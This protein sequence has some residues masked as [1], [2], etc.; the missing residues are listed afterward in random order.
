MAINATAV[1]TTDIDSTKVLKKVQE[2]T[3]KLS[4]IAASKIAPVFDLDEAQKAVE[5]VYG[6]L[7]SMAD[8][9][10]KPTIDVKGIEAVDTTK[11]ASAFEAQFKNVMKVAQQLSTDISNIFSS[12]D[13]K[14]AGGAKGNKSKALA[15]DMNKL[16][17]STRESRKSIVDGFADIVS[18]ATALKNV[19]PETIASAE[20]IF[21][22][23]KKSL[24]N[25]GGGKV[26]FK[27][28]FGKVPAADLRAAMQGY[29]DAIETASK[30]FSDMLGK[31]SA[32]SV[33]LANNLVKTVESAMQV[34][35]PVSV[36]IEVAKPS[37]GVI[38]KA[39]VG[40]KSGLDTLSLK[41]SEWS[42][43]DFV[44]SFEWGQTTRAITSE[45]EAAFSAEAS[46]RKIF[47]S[48][49]SNN[50]IAGNIGYTAGLWI[51]GILALGKKLS[52]A[53]FAIPSVLA[54]GIA[55]VSSGVFGKLSASI[56][57]GISSLL[58][59][60]NAAFVFVFGALQ[61]VFNKYTIAVASSLFMASN[62]LFVTVGKKIVTS[63]YGIGKSIFSAFKSLFSLGGLGGGSGASYGELSGF[64]LFSLASVATAT[65]LAANL[66]E[67][68]LKVTTITMQ[69]GAAFKNLQSLTISLSNEFGKSA[70]D[71]AA[72]LYDVSSAGFLGN[73]AFSVLRASIQAATAG[74][75]N[76][77]VAS[78]AISRA[79][80]AF[81]L[82]VESATVV[83]DVL[84]NVVK[85]GIT[86]FEDLAQQVTRV[87]TVSNVTGVS[88][89]EL[90]AVLAFLTRNGL[91]TEQAILGVQGL[92]KSLI[93]PSEEAKEAAKN[94]GFE[95]NETALKQKG[96]IKLLQDSAPKILANK[97]VFKKLV[98]EMQGVTA[99]LS[100]ASKP[101]ELTEDLTAMHERGAAAEASAQVA[102]GFNYQ[103]E[104]FW[105]NFVN[106]LRNMGQIILPIIQPALEATVEMLSKLS[107]FAN[108]DLSGFWAGLK[109][110]VAFVGKS[111]LE[112]LSSVSLYLGQ[113]LISIGATVLPYISGIVNSV[114]QLL[115]ALIIKLAPTIFTF[116]VNSLFSRL[117]IL[118]ELIKFSFRSLGH[119]L[120]GELGWIGKGIT[121]FFKS[122]GDTLG[123][124]LE[125]VMLPLNGLVWIVEKI[126]YW[127]GIIDENEKVKV[128]APKFELSKEKKTSIADDMK[129]VTADFAKDFEVGFSALKFDFKKN[130]SIIESV[131]SSFSKFN[132]DVAIAGNKILTTSSTALRDQADSMAEVLKS[133]EEQYKKEI[134]AKQNTKADITLKFIQKQKQQMESLA[135]SLQKSELNDTLQKQQE[136]Y[137]SLAR[138][139]RDGEKNLQLSII[140][141][142]KDNELFIMKLE[143]KARSKQAF[144]NQVIVNQQANLYDSLKAK[145]L[146]LVK[147]GEKLGGGLG[148]LNTVLDD[149]FGKNV[150][151]IA[152]QYGVGKDI[153]DA[154]ELA[155]D[156]IEARAAGFEA[157]DINTI[158]TRGLMQRSDAL[159]NVLTAFK[160]YQRALSLEDV[161][162]M[163]LS[164]QIVRLLDQAE[165][166]GLDAVGR[167]ALL[168]N[169]L[170][171]EALQNLDKQI[172]G[173]KT[174]QFVEQAG[175]FFEGV[176]EERKLQERF[177]V[178]QLKV[179]D[180]T[181]EAVTRNQKLKQVVEE[182]EKK[183]GEI[184]QI[185]G[186]QNQVLIQVP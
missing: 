29:K 106:I 69:T 22:G 170:T 7:K 64:Q 71:V 84:F 95:W 147:A 30:S 130:D 102:L 85:R 143:A 136:L 46:G 111:L 57:R 54:R 17:A 141:Q 126:A 18:Q 25:A 127:L 176:S 158:V 152:K 13:S 172:S 171:E 121:S 33:P 113:E 100:I 148:N 133:L 122:I 139:R 178:A 40:V 20:S 16:A 72:S 94:L 58:A 129:K 56:L 137:I 140:E 182:L 21:Q 62:K 180:L 144:N 157:A 50:N 124:V 5:H 74:M 23:L 117:Y 61:K 128:D 12:L 89:Q 145:V 168:Q 159:T 156:V 24:G 146:D 118:W 2:I 83:S 80:R 184:E 19:A 98:G 181:K 27:S 79:L 60:F 173:D 101:F 91:K 135:E 99:A 115:F 112:M 36:P 186:K 164:G 3:A 70:G 92:L 183:I 81:N 26:A 73:E 8:M 9:V 116:L 132:S 55:A 155:R 125:A 53:L 169:S 150:E 1:L 153:A 149:V 77:S 151:R 65:K 166:L 107:A 161:A 59:P 37:A 39:W 66:E 63:I 11:A 105:T 51:D 31:S 32:T 28:F 163:G 175:K 14:V 87:L 177:N 88:L 78:T 86:T 110:Q 67:A 103:L 35:K 160:K 119:V 34:A 165:A 179:S 68:M 43:I 48:L 131:T 47:N 45:A 82:P 96:F 167:R 123:A 185:Q 4:S 97:D 109:S 15:Q 42:K 120:E 138:A 162:K 38:S 75:T 90:G 44:R 108:T 104:K 154:R 142:I 134:A 10:I 41:A 6:R 49:F 174:V 93:S 76:T 52:V 114:G